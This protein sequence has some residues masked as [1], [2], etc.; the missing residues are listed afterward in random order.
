[1]DNVICLTVFLPALGIVCLICPQPPDLLTHHWLHFCSEGIECWDDGGIWFVCKVSPMFKWGSCVNNGHKIGLS[2]HWLHVGWFPTFQRS[3]AM[4]SRC[5]NS[6]SVSS[7]KGQQ[8]W[9]PSMQ[10]LHFSQR[11]FCVT[12]TPSTRPVFFIFWIIGLHT[13]KIIVGLGSGSLNY[14]VYTSTGCNLQ[15][16]AAVGCLQIQTTI[17]IT[18]WCYFH[19]A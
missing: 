2:S 8:V 17:N 13:Y 14:T 3:K 5:S 16:V 9:C 15:Q 12:L 18:G 19:K 7:S 4:S 1:M 11:S 6:F 10:S